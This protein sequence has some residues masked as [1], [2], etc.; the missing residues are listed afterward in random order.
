[1]IGLEDGAQ[2]LLII[3]LLLQT[4]NAS[5]WSMTVIRLGTL[6]MGGSMV[7]IQ[8]GYWYPLPSLALRLLESTD[9]K[10]NSPGMKSAQ[11]LS[12]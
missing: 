9:R 5:D 12:L 8:T 4:V 10:E 6:D 3:A 1:L 7:R 2:E 11:L